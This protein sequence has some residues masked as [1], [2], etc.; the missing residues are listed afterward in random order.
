M[1]VGHLGAGLAAKAI[2]PRLKLGTL[3]AAALFADI[4]LWLFVLGGIEQVQVPAD[5]ASHHLLVFDFRYSHS[6]IGI[7]LLSF[8]FALAWAFWG[9]R[10]ARRQGAYWDGIA[11]IAATGLTHWVL[12]VIVHQADMPVFPGGTL[13]GF[14]LWQYQPAAL[15]VELGLGL[16]AY[17]AFALRCPM[18]AG[19][20]LVVGT[21]MA[22]AGALTLEGVYGVLLPDAGIIAIS[23]LAVITLTIAIAAWADRSR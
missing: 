22:M 12:D 3:F 7:V 21:L 2:E 4:A 18:K 23:S 6:L 5:Y 15:I 16:A 8:A 19:R 17:T 14:G 11:L 20:K 13:L 1:F 9:G 10:R